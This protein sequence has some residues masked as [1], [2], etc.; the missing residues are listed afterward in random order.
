VVSYILLSN[1]PIEVKLD[2]YSLYFPS[3]DFIS[4]LFLDPLFIS[5][6]IVVSIPFL[7]AFANFIKIAVNFLISKF[8]GKFSGWVS[9]QEAKR[10]VERIGELES[11]HASLFI[12]KDVEIDKLSSKYRELEKQISA[13]QLLH[14][15]EQEQMRGEI[16][17]SIDTAKRLTDKANKELNELK[18]KYLAKDAECENLQI[19]VNDINKRFNEL[20]SIKMEEIQKL[21]QYISLKNQVTSQ[22]STIKGLN[23]RIQDDKKLYDQKM[24]TFEQIITQGVNHREN[25]FM[26]IMEKYESNF[27]VAASLLERFHHE[28]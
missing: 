8:Q 5:L 11:E 21:P 12:N 20:N 4:F 13:N 3:D 6:A 14:V 19:S 25:Q 7:N 16:N 26:K 15:K 23:Q 24:H 22:Q 18:E 2:K 10:L 17:K 1:K 27:S 28:K 9:P